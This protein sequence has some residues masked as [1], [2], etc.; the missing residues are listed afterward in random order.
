MLE[1]ES[2]LIGD[3]KLAAES[4][5]LTRAVIERIN[6]QIKKNQELLDKIRTERKA[7]Y[8]SRQAMRQW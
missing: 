3:R 1:S 2:Q 5:R 6:E 8:D 7:K 4:I